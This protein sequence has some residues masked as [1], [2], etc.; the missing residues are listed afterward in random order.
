[1]LY[2]WFANPISKE[3]NMSYKLMFVLN[4][5]VLLA[6]GLLLLVMPEMGLRQFQMD[7]RVTEIYLARV[8]GAALVSFGLVF[9]FAKNDEGA[10]KNLGMASLAGAVLALIVTIMGAAS[11]IIRTN[12]WIAIVIEVVFA[13]GYAFM[14]FLKPKMKE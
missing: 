1:M 14:L 13:L 12:G 2:I 5:I 6:L 11:G 10:H 7:A 3:R 9:W 4:A 8:L